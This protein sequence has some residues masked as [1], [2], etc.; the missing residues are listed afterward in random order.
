MLFKELELLNKF[1]TLWLPYIAFGL[2]LPVFLVDSFVRNISKEI[3]E[4]AY[5]DGSNIHQ[6]I[7]KIIMPLCR[8]VFATV[9][10]LSILSV[11]NE[12]VYALVLLNSETYRTLPI[13]LTYFTTQYSTIWTLQ[14]AGMV[15]ASTPIIV[16]YMFLSKRVMQGMTAGAVKV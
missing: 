16:V 4:A 8:P 14:M 5:M 13:G 3:E 12:L 1:Y 10:I 6:L 9:V 15:I 7:F 2:P 11:W